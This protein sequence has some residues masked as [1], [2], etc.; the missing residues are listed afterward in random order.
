MPAFP[1]ITFTIANGASLSDAQYVENSALVALLVPGTIV[2][3]V[4]SF[5]ISNDNTTFYNVYSGGLEY[6]EPVTASSATLVDIPSFLGGAYIKVRTGTSG[7]ASTQSGDVQII[8][9]LR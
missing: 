2:G 4:F 8:G 7:S 5:Q 3:T 1:Q 6:T 9:V